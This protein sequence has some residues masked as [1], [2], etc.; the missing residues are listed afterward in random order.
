MNL[1]RAKLS[2]IIGP[3]SKVKYDMTE[4]PK[5]TQNRAII[6]DTYI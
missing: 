6:F 1:K 4:A 3:I 5:S 2:I